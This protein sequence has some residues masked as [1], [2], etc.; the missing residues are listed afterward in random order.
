MSSKNVKGKTALCDG[1]FT[2]QKLRTQ[3]KNYHL[4]NT[5]YSNYEIKIIKLQIIQTNDKNSL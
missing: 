5:N 3:I 1:I 4:F 2:Y